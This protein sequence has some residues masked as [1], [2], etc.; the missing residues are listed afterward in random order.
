MTIVALLEWLVLLPLWRRMTASRSWHVAG[1]VGTALAWFIVIIAIA[2][3]VAGGDEDDDKELAQA[4][5]PSPE[6]EPTVL[7][8]VVPAPSPTVITQEVVPSPTVIVQEAEAPAAGATFG[9]GIHVVG[10]DIQPGT[11]RNSPTG[12]LCY[13]ARLS[14]FGGSDIITNGIGEETQIVTISASDAGFESEDCGSWSK[15]D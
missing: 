7:T 6:M 2:A 15:M 11:Y 4:V 3:A 1:G 10:T 12:D 8:T 14:G 13:W 9:D 5:C